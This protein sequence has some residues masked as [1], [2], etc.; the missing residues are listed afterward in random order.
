MGG[1]GGGS[2]GAGVAGGV[3][4]AEVAGV[5]LRLLDREDRRMQVSAVLDAERRQPLEDLVA[6]GEHG[7]AP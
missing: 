4:A 6:R 3:A 7:V 5:H 2:S 1:L